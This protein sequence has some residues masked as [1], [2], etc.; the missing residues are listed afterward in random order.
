MK[1]NAIQQYL[2]GAKLDPAS[3]IL[4][5]ALFEF[6]NA[7][8]KDVGTRDIAKRAGVNI[9][10]ISYYFKGKD[11]LYSELVS[12]ITQYFCKCAAPF[13][14]RLDALLL[15]PSKPEARSLLRDY[16]SWR[17]GMV[18]EKNELSK[19]IIS[20]VSREEFNN[21]PLFKKLYSKVLGKADT[22][23][24]ATLKII[25]D[26]KFDDESYKIMAV[27]FAGALIRF[28]TVPDSV[29]LTLGWDKI[30]RSGVDKINRV[31]HSMLDTLLKNA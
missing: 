1:T 30:E 25:L 8:V 29:M 10:A 24:A 9:A 20:I 5:A 16:I 4:I 21:T 12:Q 11:E 3:K 17:V 27:A 31:I 15:A 7:P 26:K 2:D 6:G 13:H 22:L 18:S 14:E 28:G 23:F 19:S